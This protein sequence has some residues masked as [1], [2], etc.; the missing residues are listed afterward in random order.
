MRRIS[1]KHAKPGMVL[2]APVY[3]NYGNVLLDKS[4]TLDQECLQALKKQSS[5]GNPG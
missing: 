3:N 5:Q 1:T 2:G 4:T